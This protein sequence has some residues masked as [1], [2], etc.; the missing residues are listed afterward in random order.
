MGD[1]L[2]RIEFRQAWLLLAVLAALPVFWLARSAGGRLKFSSLAP[3]PASGRSLRTAL[4]WLPP[5]LLALAAALLGLAL[6][7]PRIG[8]TG[9]EITREGIAIMMVVDTSGSMAALDLS[10]KHRERTRLDAV[11]DVFTAFE[12]AQHGFWFRFAVRLARLAAPV[13]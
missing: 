6:A 12:L 1:L 4:A 5:A 11:K 13:Q 9:G 7:G 2:A 8:K 10:E 3:L